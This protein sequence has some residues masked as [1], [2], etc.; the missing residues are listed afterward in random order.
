MNTYRITS[1]TTTYTIYDIDAETLEE[2]EELAEAV[3]QHP[4]QL[5]GVDIEHDTGDTIKPTGGTEAS[6]KN[7]IFGLGEL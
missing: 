1:R 7:R 5:E 4:D 2:A 6:A 3:R